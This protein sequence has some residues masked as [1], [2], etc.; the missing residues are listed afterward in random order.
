MVRCPSTQ[1]FG[2]KGAAHALAGG[3]VGTTVVLLVGMQSGFPARGVLRENGGGGCE[4]L[5]EWEA[6]V[7]RKDLHGGIP[8][9]PQCALP[10][11]SEAAKQMCAACKSLGYC[12]REHQRSDWKDHKVE[13]R[14]IVKSEAAS[15]EGGAAGGGASEAALEGKDAGKGDGGEVVEQPTPVVRHD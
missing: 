5:V 14:R 3:R 9:I 11:C 10:S 6:A 12:S 1:K 13:C 2:M 4:A 8:T 15:G 7:E